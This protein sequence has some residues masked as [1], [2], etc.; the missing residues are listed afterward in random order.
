M[1]NQRILGFAYVAASV[2]VFLVTRQFVD[3]LFDTVR[4]TNYAL[5]PFVISDVL[6]L[7]I[8]VGAAIGT[9]KYPKVHDFLT[10]V[11][12]ET[13][14]VVWPSRQETRDSTVVVIVFVFVV[15]A[16]LGGFDLLWAKVTN[17]ILAGPAS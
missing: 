3:W 17:L 11:V 2:L 13:S 9:W 4:L 5:G 14:K 6:A 7:L 16:I 1:S 15:A 8:V 10:E 12:E